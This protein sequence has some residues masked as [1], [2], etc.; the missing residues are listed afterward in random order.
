MDRPYFELDFT[1][2]T[3]VHSIASQVWADIELNELSC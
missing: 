2:Y 1:N 3:S